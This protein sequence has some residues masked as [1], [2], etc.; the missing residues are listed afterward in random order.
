MSVE[1]KDVTEVTPDEFADMTPKERLE[2]TGETGDGGSGGG[3]GLTDRLS[4]PDNVGDM[5][6]S[7]LQSRGEG[8]DISTVQERYNAP[9]GLAWIV[10]G[11]TRWVGVDD[12]PPPADIVVG[13]LKLKSQFTDE[14]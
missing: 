14:K 4:V 3:S 12:V 6:K 2:L 9:E 13:V 8:V 5:A 10:Q 7:L 1:D 11:V